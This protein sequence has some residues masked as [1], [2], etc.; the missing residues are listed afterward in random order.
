MVFKFAVTLL[1]GG[2]VIGIDD[3]VR[4]FAKIEQYLNVNVNLNQSI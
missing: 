2:S 3:V 1:I 4:A